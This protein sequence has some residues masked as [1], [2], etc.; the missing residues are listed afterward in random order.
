MERIDTPIHWNARAEE[1]LA[2]AEKAGHPE[3]RHAL[4]RI[5]NMYKNLA[6]KAEKRTRIRHNG[7]RSEDVALGAIRAPYNSDKT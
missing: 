4:M 5:A 7:Q 6:A 3:T 1:A 2:M